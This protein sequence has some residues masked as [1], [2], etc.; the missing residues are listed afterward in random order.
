MGMLLF[1][2]F[3]G[4]AFAQQPAASPVKVEENVLY[5]TVDG[6]ELRLDVYEPA[7]H[8]SEISAGGPADPRRRF[9]Q[10]DQ[11]NATDGPVSCAQWF[12]RVRRRLSRL[13][14][15]PRIAGRRSLTTCSARLAGCGPMPPKYGVNPD[16]I[17]AF[18][19]SAG[20]QLAA[21][22]GMEDT[23]R[24]LRC[25]AGKILEPGA[26]SS[27]VMRPDRLYR[28]PRKGSAEFAEKFFGTSYAQNPEVWR[29]A[30]PMYHVSKQNAPFLILHGTRIERSHRAGAEILRQITNG[31]SAGFVYQSQ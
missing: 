9:D 27:G 22:L 17:G 4:M 7:T 21:L 26:G 15:G 28:R 5:A 16:R 29:D 19:H 11:H 12:C 20:A 6:S 30:S 25:G 1:S 2:V 23:P 8:G 13:F 24:Q 18:G 14:H 10:L 3:L 31:W